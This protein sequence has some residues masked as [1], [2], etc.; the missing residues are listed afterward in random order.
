F[1]DQAARL[2]ARV[3]YA[4]CVGRDAFGDA[5]VARLE[6]DGVDVA[7]I[8]RVGRPTGTAFVAYRDDGSRSFVFTLSTSAAAC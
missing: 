7:R 3:A 6:R 1:A 8:R 2:G 5:I 4:G